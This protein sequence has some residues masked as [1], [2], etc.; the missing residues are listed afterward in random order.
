VTGLAASGD[1]PRGRSVLLFGPSD[2]MIEALDRCLRERGHTVTKAAGDPGAALA[3]VPD[4]VVFAAP[5]VDERGVFAE[6]AVL[7]ERTLDAIDTGVNGFLRD[8]QAF[9]KAML[10]RGGQIWA[11]G[12]DDSFGYYLDIPVAPM[13]T[14]ARISFLRAMAKE[15][16]RFGIAF[17]AAIVQPTPDVVGEAVFKGRS[18][19]LKSYALK[20]RPGN[21]SAFATVLASLIEN[22]ALP[23]NGATL[24]LGAGVNEHNF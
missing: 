3:D 20:Y 2:G 5:D 7:R 19:A 21:A 10:A 6:D 4:V 11:L 18:G 12:L 13:V 17:N 16:G 15:Y 1:K 22:P 24:H 9:A 23:V 14:S 8:A